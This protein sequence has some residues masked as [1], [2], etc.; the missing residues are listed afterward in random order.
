MSKIKYKGGCAVMLKLPEHDQVELDSL[1]VQARQSEERSDWR[2]LPPETYHLTLQFVGRDLSSEKI[3]RVV[4]STFLFA[5]DEAPFQIEF[6]GVT[7]VNRTSKG[8]YLVAQVIKSNNILR[9]RERILDKFAQMD[10]KVK[11]GFGF[12]PHVTIAE[13]DPGR[14]WPGE[15]PTSKSFSVD[16]NELVLKYGARRMSIDL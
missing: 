5:E 7:S 9:M 16:C 12:N 15:L 3:S 10:V 13:A 14:A 2:I 11:D 4:F 1:R 6:T 8:S